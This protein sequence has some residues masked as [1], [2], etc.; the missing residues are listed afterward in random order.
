MRLLVHSHRPRWRTVG[1]VVLAVSCAYFGAL[2]F[3]NEY[4]SRPVYEAVFRDLT[5][6][7]AISRDNPAEVFSVVGLT[8]AGKPLLL[9]HSISAVG[10]F[11]RRVW[12]EVLRDEDLVNNRYSF[13]LDSAQIPVL[14]KALRDGLTD[15]R[16][17]TIR[18]SGDDRSVKTQRIF[19]TYWNDDDGYVSVYDVSARGV[20]AREYA[21]VTRRDAFLAWQAQRARAGETFRAG[22]AVFVVAAALIIVTAAAAVLHRRSA[23]SGDRR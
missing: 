17:V 18:I 5:T 9:L 20:I 22:A 2:T 8:L 12:A 1:L 21:D 14:E 16:S 19:L 15:A 13:Y 11:D 10:V 4:R 3:V 6:P 7:R 23:T